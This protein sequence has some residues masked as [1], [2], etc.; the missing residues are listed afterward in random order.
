[1]AMAMA[2][3]MQVSITGKNSKW[4]HIPSTYSNEIAFGFYSKFIPNSQHIF[5]FFFKAQIPF[6][7]NFL[8]VSPFQF[9]FVVD[10][11]VKNIYFWNW[12]CC[13]CCCCL[14][15]WTNLIYECKFSNKREI[16]VDGGGGGGFETGCFKIMFLNVHG[17]DFRY[18]Y[19]FKFEYASG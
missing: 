14:Y 5:S 3:T 15:K 8:H 1:M 10:Q 17:I 16:G 6:S 2:M 9:A 11:N 19:E 7:S 18:L 12:F 13:C 4:E